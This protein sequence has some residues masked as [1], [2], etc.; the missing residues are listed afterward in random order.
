M[1]PAGSMARTWKVWEPSARPL[2]ALGEVQ[3]A[4]ASLSSLHWKVVF[5][6]L[7]E[8]EKLA[9]ALLSVPPAAGPESMKVSGAVRSAV[10]TKLNV[11]L[12]SAK[13][14]EVYPLFVMSAT[15]MA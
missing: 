12:V 7:D 11:P 5:G 1:L 2:R 3:A 10:T 15:V 8:K 6:S 13:S 4:K 9:E 14:P